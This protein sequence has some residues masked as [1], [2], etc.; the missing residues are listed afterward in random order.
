MFK[1]NQCVGANALSDFSM[2]RALINQGF[3]VLNK[4]GTGECE[5]RFI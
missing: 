2:N 4:A 3:G 5:R 1:E